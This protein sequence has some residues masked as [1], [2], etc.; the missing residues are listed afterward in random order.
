MTNDE[1][2]MTELAILLHEGVPLAPHDIWGAWSLEAGVLLGL[3]G[4]ALLYARGSH[5]LRRRSGRHHAARG[6]EAA[7]FW[8]GWTLLLVALVSPLHRMGGALLWAHMAQHEL[9]M[10]VVAPLLVMGRPV[11][12]SLWAPG[13]YIR[14]RV[15]SWL[16][17]LQPLSRWLSRLEVTWVLHAAAIVVWHAPSL[18][19]RTVTS[20]L[21]HSLQ[22]ASF[23]GTA[24]L[25]WWSVL[26]EARLRG[27]HG[28]AVLSLFT[29]AIYT[30]GLGALLTVA[31]RPWYPAYGAAAPLWGLTPIEDQQLA[32]L[33]M[34]VPAGVSYLIAT[35]WLA[36]AWLRESEPRVVSVTDAA[37]ATGHFRS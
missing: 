10:V 18:Y 30:G 2:L 34:W 26:T 23:L 27:R 19:G 7:A 22:H 8:A 28:G 4:T 17:R 11:L 12:V 13:P 20:E 16:G 35:M 15:G 1:V 5:R 6:K 37:R 36:A 29:T 25:Y 32:G 31:G 9:L 14:R 33:I 24:L 3:G 21:V